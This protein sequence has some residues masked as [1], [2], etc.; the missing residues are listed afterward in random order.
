MEYGISR[1][2]VIR[3]ASEAGIEVVEEAV[4]ENMKEYVH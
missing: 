1:Q 4:A 2:H 3:L